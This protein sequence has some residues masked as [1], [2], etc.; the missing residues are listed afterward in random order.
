MCGI[1]G[2]IGPR[3]LDD[4]RIHKTLSTMVSRGPDAQRFVRFERGDVH[5]VLLHSRLSIID[6]DARAH[7]P[8]RIGPYSLVFNGEIYN[9]LEVKEQLEKIG[10]VFQTASDTEVLLQS[11]ITYGESCVD[12]F[13]GMWAFCIFDENTSSLVLSRDR[14]AEKPLYFARFS[15]GFYP[16][17]AV[18]PRVP[19]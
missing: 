2:Y 9:Y 1:A 11:Y 16:P 10:V 8:F 15:D 14:F 3:L 17:G 7:Q 13:E 12:Q 4:S 19:C 6:L 5:T 18:R